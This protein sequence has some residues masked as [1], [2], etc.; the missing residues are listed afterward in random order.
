MNLKDF[1]FYMF[2]PT[3]V[4]ETNFPR[5]QSFRI[6]YFLGHVF[7]V[8]SNMFVQYFVVTEDILPI[9]KLNRTAPLLILYF[10]LQMKLI[11]MLFLN[12]FLIFES[13]PNA[14]SELTYYADR[15]FY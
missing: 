10:K 15:E 5:K 1:M 7:M 9:I 3:L 13:L 12:I 2:A 14:V 8:L 6:W 4:Y 11:L